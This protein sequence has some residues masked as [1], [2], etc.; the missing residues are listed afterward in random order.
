MFKS[1]FCKKKCFISVK[2]RHHKV[3]YPGWL[4]T[5][6]AFLTSNAWFSVS[7][8]INMWHKQSHIACQQ[9][10]MPKNYKKSM[11]TCN[12]MTE[13]LKFY[14]TFSMATRPWDIVERVEY[15]TQDEMCDQG[16]V[17]YHILKH[18]S[19]NNV[20]DTSNSWFVTLLHT[21]W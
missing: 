18:V 21:L 5:G 6:I 3:T 11:F 2:K 15:W 10:K 9:Q 14:W 7:H 12:R 8:S 17:Y 4:K 1:Q 19:Y 20:V 13:K 16:L